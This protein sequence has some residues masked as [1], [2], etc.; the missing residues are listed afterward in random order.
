MAHETEQI[1]RSAPLG[2]ASGEGS[3]ANRLAASGLPASQL[4][5]DDNAFKSYCTGVAD[6]RLTLSGVLAGIGLVVCVGTLVGL[7]KID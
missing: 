2:R 1:A 4:Q 5:A 7:A 3:L 6:T